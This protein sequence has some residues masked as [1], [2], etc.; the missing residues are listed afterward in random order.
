MP[1]NIIFG[2]KE[3]R[4]YPAMYNRNNEKRL[5]SFCFTTIKLMKSEV[6]LKIKKKDTETSVLVLVFIKFTT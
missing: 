4:F 5:E 2:T 6:I 1:F 3:K